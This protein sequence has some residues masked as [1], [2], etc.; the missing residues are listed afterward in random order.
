MTVIV[1]VLAIVS[2]IVSMLNWFKDSALRK[3]NEE[4]TILLFHEG[5]DTDNCWRGAEIGL[6]RWHNSK[7]GEWA[8]IR[9]SDGEVEATFSFEQP[10]I[11]SANQ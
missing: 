2:L 10:D 4:A 6:S 1:F 7:T 5:W 9:R 3:D 11:E 8:V